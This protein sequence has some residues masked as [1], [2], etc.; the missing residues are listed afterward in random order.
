MFSSTFASVADLARQSRFAD[1]EFAVAP[2]VGVRFLVRGGG[3][4]A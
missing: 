3:P 2:I 1:G 4:L